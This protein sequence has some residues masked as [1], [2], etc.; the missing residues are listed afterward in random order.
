MFFSLV[1][2]A[3]AI[4]SS[5][6]GTDALLVEDPTLVVMELGEG[7]CRD[8]SG[9]N[10]WD[11]SNQL[12]VSSLTECGNACLEL[13]GCACI[14]YA[15]PAVDTL[16]NCLEQNLYRCVIYL[17]EEVATSSNGHEGYVALVPARIELV[18]ECEPMVGGVN[19]MAE[20]EATGWDLSG[21][22]SVSMPSNIAGCADSWYGWNQND[23]VGTISY[24]FE[25]EDGEYQ[26]AFSN[27][28]S[29]ADSQAAAVLYLNGVEVMSAATAAG[30]AVATGLFVKGDVLE[31]K[32]EGANSVVQV[33]SFSI[34]C[35]VPEYN[36]PWVQNNA[37]TEEEVELEGTVASHDECID[38]VLQECPDATVANMGLDGSCW[39]QAGDNMTE[40]TT[41]DYDSCLLSSIP[42]YEYILVDGPCD[43]TCEGGVRTPE[44]LCVVQQ[45]RMAAEGM[46]VGEM[47]EAPLMACNSDVVCEYGCPWVSNNANMEEEVE[48]EGTVATNDE[49]ITRVMNECPDATIANVGGDGSCWCQTGDD[50]TEDAESEYDSCLLSSIPTYEY[51]LIDNEC[52]QTCR[53]GVQT[54]EAVCVVTGTADIAEGRC[55]GLIPLGSPQLCNADVP[56]ATL[57]NR[58]FYGGVNVETFLSLEAIFKRAWASVAGVQN[59]FVS[60]GGLSAVLRRRRQLQNGVTVDWVVDLDSLTSD[61]VT[62]LNDVVNGPNFDDDL[63]DRTERETVLLLTTVDAEQEIPEYNCVTVKNNNNFDGE[64]ELGEADSMNQCIQKVMLECPDA[65]IANYSP[66]SGG[67]WCQFGTDMTE[68]PTSDFENCLLS[69]LDDPS[70]MFWSFFKTTFHQKRKCHGFAKFSKHIF[71]LHKSCHK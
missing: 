11:F 42:V 41:S 16:N 59:A 58:V 9:N 55:A 5:S 60:L 13:D 23:E 70:N 15:E 30:V 20:M 47:P 22:A 40:D 44:V 6:D 35:P 56:C 43:S 4:F 12:C 2:L 33:V 71:L 52:S 69:T 64:T 14:S 27:C 48:L 53:G 34:A 19:S 21:M 61:E 29:N 1:I 54:P 3:T 32:D 68:D 66:V 17:G 18:L 50:M 28:W 49:C 37:N 51:I 57:N 45:T 65:T 26:I 67:C 8:E 62:A 10:P 63:Q 39:C 31:L 7:Y 46:C 24:T 38:R 25:M 36:C